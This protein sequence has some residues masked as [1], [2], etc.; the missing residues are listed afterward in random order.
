MSAWVLIQLFLNIIFAVT[1]FILWARLSRSPKEDPR[2]SKG[3][4]VLQTKISILEDLSDRTDKQVRDLCNIIEKKSKEV[5]SAIIQSEEQISKIGHSMRKSMEV[6]NIFQDKIPHDEILERKNSKKY[7]QAA[8]LA[9]RGMSP[10]EISQKID[11]SIPEIEFICKVNKDRLMFNEEQLPVWA[12][13]VERDMGEVFSQNHYA[14]LKGLGEK[15]R[16]ASISSTHP[17]QATAAPTTV[18]AAEPA[19]PARFERISPQAIDVLS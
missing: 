7:V 1:I 3:L 2:L 10:Q 18:V 13:P 8:L 12:K 16:N 9:H 14:E 5:E 6:A 11:L 4:Q 19:S 17:T 15:F